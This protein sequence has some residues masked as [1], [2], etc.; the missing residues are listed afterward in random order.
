MKPTDQ[1]SKTGSHDR[2]TAHAHCPSCEATHH[3]AESQTPGPDRRSFLKTGALTAGVA[4][5]GATLP[6]QARR[7]PGGGGNPTKV[8]VVLF[9]RGGADGLNL[10]APTDDPDYA[11]VRPGIAIT[12]PGSGDPFEGLQLTNMFSMHPSM[13]NLAARFRA[14]N[15]DLAIVPA[16]GQ[17]PYDLSH[18]ES[19][20]L[21]E[22]GSL[23]GSLIDGWVNRHLQATATPLDSP[24]RA[25][26]LRDSLPRSLSGSYP[27]Y[28]VK[29]MRDMAF[30]GSA[31]DVRQYLE[32]ITNGT[33]T[34]SMSPARQMAYQTGIDC[35]ELIDYFTNINPSNYTPA[36]G[37]VYP[38]SSLGTA[39]REAAEVIKAD[40]GV[41]FFAIDQGGWDHHSNQTS[42]LNTLAIDYD[43]AI[44][45]FLTDLGAAAVDVVVLG[46]TEFGRTAAQNGSG[47]TDHGVGGA[48]LL[49]G[50]PVRGGQT[51][52][53]WPGLAPAALLNSRYLMPTVDFRDVI[54]EVLE[55]HMGGTDPNVVF[56]GHTYVPV[57]LI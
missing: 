39:M 8:T 53:N 26:A 15:S 23:D 29:R 13:P 44:T 5:I 28:A 19:Q 49:A 36:N 45:A 17:Q 50:G 7:T 16:V 14:A 47:G 9:Q 4:A 27:C 46:M 32:T 35:F 24:V 10:Y 11:N 57:D 34:G 55:D 20:D 2:S 56:P 6:A 54:L 41:E 51:Y 3:E 1:P 37:A 48:M 31:S 21:F 33:P 12:P 40:L 43:Q 25:L 38:S 30:H 22:T 42:R 52:G 18:F